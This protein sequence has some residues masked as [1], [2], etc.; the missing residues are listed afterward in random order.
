MTDSPGRR[1]VVTAASAVIDDRRQAAV[2]RG[3]EIT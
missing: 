3:M 1:G 2:G